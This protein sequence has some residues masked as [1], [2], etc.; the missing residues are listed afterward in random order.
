MQEINLLYKSHFGKLVATLLK[1]FPSVNL[2]TIEDQVQDAF[3]AALPVWKRDGIPSNPAGWIFTVSRNK[4]LNT[5]K[6][7]KRTRFLYEYEDFHAPAAGTR[8]PAFDDQQ[9][10]L[11]FACAH[12]DLA[13]K[14]QVVITLK[15]VVN[16]KVEAIA[17]VLGMTI[18]GIDKLLVRARQKIRDEKILFRE[19]DLHN[20]GATLK[21]RLPIVNKIIYL[22][23]NEGYKTSWGK[24]IIRE[25]LCEEALLMCKALFD[26]KMHNGETAALYALMLFNAARLKARFGPAGELL[27]LEE[28]DRSLWNRNLIILA[29]DVLIQAAEAPVSTYHFEA[30]IAWLH[31]TV[32]DFQS[33]DWK[34]ISNL[35][36]QL[37]QMNANPFVELN[38]AI[39]LYYAGDKQQ[40]FEILNNLRL[41]TFL[42][43]YYLL[44][45]SLGKLHF[46]AGNYLAAKDFYRL[47]LSQTSCQP[48]KDFIEKMITRILPLIAN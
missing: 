8:E 20:A 2:E 14:V 25:E 23:F 16:L 19:P 17:K 12:P 15:Y 27:E 1:A 13:P 3:A 21:A 31:C 42:S 22:V 26:H 6:E 4:V 28:Q 30:S 46:L 47:A 10:Q 5:I 44:N 18:D 29:S 37:L 7:E 34:S 36:R 41:H 48:E 24:E 40:S 38:Y 43:Q 45:A 33:T 39:A 32:R 9:L 11:L 35:Y